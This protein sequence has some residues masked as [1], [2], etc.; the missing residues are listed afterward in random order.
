MDKYGVSPMKDFLPYI[1]AFFGWLGSL[2][3]LLIASV[4]VA[5]FRAYTAYKEYKLKE[6][7]LDAKNAT[8]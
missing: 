2:N 6:R 3:W 1:M 7:E 4:A 5:A 8:D